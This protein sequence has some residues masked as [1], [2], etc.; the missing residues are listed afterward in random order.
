MRL[1]IRPIHVHNRSVGCR[2]RV[3]HSAPAR[4]NQARIES[5]ARYSLHLP[6]MTDAASRRRPSFPQYIIRI[7]PIA[8]RTTQ[9]Y[10]RINENK[11]LRI[12]FLGQRISFIFVCQ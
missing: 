8:R 1:Q 9:I 10:A 6:V 2:A 5:F 12:H 11:Q 4:R 7:F 3:T